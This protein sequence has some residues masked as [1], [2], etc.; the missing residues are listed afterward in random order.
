MKTAKKKGPGRPRKGSEQS[1]SEGVLVRMAPSEKRG[2]TDAAHLAGAPLCVWIR[3][4]LRAIAAKELHSAGREVP[5][6]T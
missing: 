3:E 5:F 6:L 1:K 2:F 4:R